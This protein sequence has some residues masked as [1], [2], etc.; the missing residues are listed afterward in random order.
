MVV[1][2]SDDQVLITVMPEKRVG[3]HFDNLVLGGG[4]IALGVILETAQVIKLNWYNR[5]CLWIFDLKGTVQDAELKPMISVKL[6]NQ[7]PRLVAKSEFLGVTRE[8]NLGDV[9]AKKLSFLSL[10]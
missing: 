3:L 9:H 1:F 8:H 5:A 6:R 7:I 10:T 2:V 4:G